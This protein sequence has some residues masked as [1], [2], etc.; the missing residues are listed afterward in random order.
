MVP[1]DA[2]RPV[3]TKSSVA[4]YLKSVS[5]CKPISTGICLISSGLNPLARAAARNLIKS[6]SFRLK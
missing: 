4:L 1:V 5:P 2:L 6:I 3:F